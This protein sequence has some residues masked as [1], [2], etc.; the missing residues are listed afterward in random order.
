MHLCLFIARVLKLFPLKY[1]VFEHWIYLQCVFFNF[2]NKVLVVLL[3]QQIISS[4]D[5]DF[6]LLMTNLSHDCW[7]YAT[8]IACEH[9]LCAFMANFKNLKEFIQVNDR[10]QGAKSRLAV[11]VSKCPFSKCCSQL[12]LHVPY[13]L[14]VQVEKFSVES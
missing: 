8:V 11:P 1:H 2:L 9:D 12:K 7:G 4:T 13:I 5:H 14:S 3:V 10:K 6:C